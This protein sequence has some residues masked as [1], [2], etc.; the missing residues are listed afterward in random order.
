MLDKLGVMTRRVQD[1]MLVMRP[2][3]GPDG[4]DRSAV[5]APLDFD[6][7]KS[8]KGLRV[9]YVEAWMK[10]DP[11]TDVD[12]AALESARALGMRPEPFALPD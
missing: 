3:A 8:V 4:R 1:A 5:A 9:G 6:A 2:I 10:D 12:H 11:A 7:S